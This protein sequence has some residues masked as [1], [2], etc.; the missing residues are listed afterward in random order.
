MRSNV[1]NGGMLMEPYQ[2]HASRNESLDRNVDNPSKSDFYLKAFP[3]VDMSDE[4]EFA[5]TQL[6]VMMDELGGKNR[7]VEPPERKAA[8]RRR[9][10]QSFR[11]D[12]KRFELAEHLIAVLPCLLKTIFLLE[13]ENGIARK[14]ILKLSVFRRMLLC[15]D[16]AHDWI[17]YML[18]QHGT[19]AQRCVDYFQLVSETTVIDFTGGFKPTS[20]EDVEAYQAARQEVFVAVEALKGTISALVM[21]DTADTER[22][23]ATAVVWRIMSNKLGRPF[24]LGLVLIDL[25]LHVRP[26]YV[27]VFTLLQRTWLFFAHLFDFHLFHINFRSL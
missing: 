16:H 3:R 15:P 5:F 17:T 18:K 26:S 25:I 21:L 2:S 7:L 10:R 8:P 11:E 9:N 19:P 12:D 4:V 13:G 14:R 1:A 23:A 22:A 6:S 27:E 20:K 24:V